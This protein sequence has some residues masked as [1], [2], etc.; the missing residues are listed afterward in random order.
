MYL[1]D[2][3][4]E[5]ATLWPGRFKVLYAVDDTAGQEWGGLVG[6]VD[7]AVIKEHMPPPGEG[8]MVMTCGP[9]PMV[10]AIAGAKTPDFKQGE[11]GGLLAELGYTTDMVWKF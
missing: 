10:A 8:T 11:V 1:Q 7:A 3:L 4:D 5:L 6:R 9:K 2:E